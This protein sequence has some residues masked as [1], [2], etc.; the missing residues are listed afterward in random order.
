[1]RGSP[2]IASLRASVLL[3]V[4]TATPASA[5]NL[6]ANSD[7]DVDLSH[8]FADSSATLTWSF[9][10]HAG[11]VASG[12][13]HVTGQGAAA[14]RA[15]HDCFP[16]DGGVTYDAS[17]WMRFALGGEQV[18]RLTLLAYSSANCSSGF[19]GVQDAT[20]DALQTGQWELAVGQVTTPP[21]AQSAEVKCE[22]GSV[23][24]VDAQCDAVFLP[25]VE[26]AGCALASL[27]GL[28]LAR[29]RAAA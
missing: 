11:N 7:F 6:V 18:G 8:W 2:F 10:D 23:S 21:T 1:M 25:E 19:L 29:R 3:A 16:I 4:V 15:I 27:A 20:E 12:S 17:V 26:G 14:I 28:A 24:G 5:A 9:D 13:A 22:F